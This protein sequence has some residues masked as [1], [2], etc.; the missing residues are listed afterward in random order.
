MLTYHERI[1]LREKL[2]N[3]EISLELPKN[4]I[5]RITKK[6]NGRGLQHIGKKDELKLLKKNAKYVIVQIKN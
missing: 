1:E 2:I 5:G 6:D 3:G 4:Y